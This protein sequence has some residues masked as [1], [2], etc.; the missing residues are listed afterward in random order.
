MRCVWN[1]LFQKRR[2][3]K[4]TTTRKREELVQC[5]FRSIYFLWISIADP[6]LYC[7]SDS[8]HLT[9]LF[10]FFFCYRECV[11]VESSIRHVIG[12]FLWNTLKTTVIQM[13]I[14]WE[15]KWKK[16]SHTH[17]HT[18]QKDQKRLSPPHAKKKNKL[19]DR[20]TDQEHNETTLYHSTNMR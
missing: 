12:W 13:P 4:T 10:F 18:S 9:G 8:R 3:K 15:I 7:V 5:P 17:T 1:V 2:K 19:T 20:P 14:F 11:H 16:K 6:I